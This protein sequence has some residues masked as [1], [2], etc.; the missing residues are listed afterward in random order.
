LLSLVLLVAV[1]VCVW[2][3]SSK[4]TPVTVVPERLKRIELDNV[5]IYVISLLGDKNSHVRLNRFKER[6]P[7]PYQL[8]NGTDGRKMDQTEWINKGVL[9]PGHPLNGGQVGCILS[10][11]GL[12]ME[13]AAQGTRYAVVLEDDAVLGRDFRVILTT[14]LGQV[15]VDF[16]ILFLGHCFEVK[17]RHVTGNIHESVYPRCTHGYVV[18]HSGLRKLGRMCMSKPYLDVPIDEWIAKQIQKKQIKAYAVHPAIV[19]TDQY[20][21]STINQTT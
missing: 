13:L 11:M 16:D 1:L 15:P 7:G 12:W 10:H 6:Y 3:A 19:T 18:S 9:S 20:V 17:G 4:G 5:T 21:E 8:F 2:F 14:L